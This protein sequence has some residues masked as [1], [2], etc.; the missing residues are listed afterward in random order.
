[1]ALFPNIF[2]LL[3]EATELKASLLFDG[4]AK[5][6]WLPKLFLSVV[7]IV[8]SCEKTVL[9]CETAVGRHLVERR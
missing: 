4:S 2:R 5:L 1:M 6:F 9:A 8:C 3:L 7:P